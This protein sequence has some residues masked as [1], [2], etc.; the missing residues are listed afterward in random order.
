MRLWAW[1]SSG[2]KP[3]LDD[4]PLVPGS[5]EHA[6]AA[7]GGAAI[8]GG[9]SRQLA[10]PPIGVPFQAPP[11]PTHFVSR[12][13][14]AGPIKERLLTE[15]GDAARVL[16]IS[17]VHGL[18]GIGKSVLAAALAYDA[19]VQ[20]HFKDGVLWASLGQQPDVL[21]L[22]SG[23]IQA[24]R[25]YQFHSL[26]IEA[27]SSHLRKLLRDKAC[28]LVIDDAWEA[29]HVLPLLAGGSG[30][31]VLITTRQALVASAAG[32]LKLDLQAMTEAQALELLGRRLPHPLKGA[33]RQQA[34]EVARLLGCLPLALELAAAHLADG[35][36]WLELR[37]ALEAQ[38]AR[39]PMLDA[40]KT[41]E[42]N[43]GAL[44]MKRGLQ[45][46]LALSLRPLTPE[47]RAAFAWLGVLPQDAVL[48]PTMAAA[49]WDL[50]DEAQA[51]DLLHY[52]SERALLLPGSPSID[53][54]LSYRVHGLLHEMACNLLTAPET[55]VQRGD[56]PGLGLLLP[57][58]NALFLG[59]HRARCA[60]APAA[61]SWHTLPNDGYIHARL[62]WHMQQASWVAE[63]HALLREETAAGRNAWFEARHRLG[64]TE[65]Y[66]Q[67]LRRAW[68][69]ACQAVPSFAEQGGGPEVGLQIRYAL[70]LASLNS[71]AASIPPELLDAL[72]KYQIWPPEQ[73]LAYA[74]QKPDPCQQSLALSALVKYLPAA[75]QEAVLAEGLAAVR[76]ANDV[77]QQAQALAAL[78]PH[79]APPL[80]GEVLAAVR[81]LLPAAG[82]DLEAPALSA[83]AIRLAQLG[84]PDEAL[85]VLAQIVPPHERAQGLAA[86]GPHLPPAALAAAL[87]LARQIP[88][89]GERALALLSLVPYL[90][91]EASAEQVKQAPAAVVTA[92][93]LEYARRLAVQREN[94]Y[95]VYDPSPALAPLIPLLARAGCLEDAV[96]LAKQILGSYHRVQALASLLPYLPLE[97]RQPTLAEAFEVA[98]AAWNDT[99]PLDLLASLAPYL[100]EDRRLA[101][102]DKVLAKPADFSEENRSSNYSED[103]LVQTLTALAPF[104]SPSLLT[105]AFNAA[106]AIRVRRLRVDALTVLAAHLPPEQQRQ[107]L[108][109]ALAAVQKIADASNSA[110]MLV[111]L[112][113]HIRLDLLPETLAVAQPSKWNRYRVQ[114][115]VERALHLADQNRLDE[116]LVVARQIESE[117]A[118]SA[119]LAD[120]AA[121]L[122]A[123][124]RKPLL[125]EALA[126]ARE[127]EWG[128]KRSQALVTVAAQLSG[129][130]RR[131]ALSE[132][133]ASARQAHD[134]MRIQALAALTCELPPLARW[135]AL[136]EA[137]LV[138]RQMQPEDLRPQAHA[139][140]LPCLPGP[141]VGWLVPGLLE[142][143]H[144]VRNHLV[145]AQT[146]AALLPYLPV[147]VR[148]TVLSEALAAARQASPDDNRVQALASLAALLKADASRHPDLLAEALTIV[149]LIEQEGF[150]AMA[151]QALAPHMGD[152]GLLAQAVQIAQVINDRL[153]RVK[154][155]AALAP[156]LPVEQQ[157]LVLAA[158]LEAARQVDN[159]RGRT[160]GLALLAPLLP[161]AQRQPVLA[162]ALSS[163][164]QEDEKW[165]RA[166]ALLA[167]AP[168]LAQLPAE[169][170]TP[171]W[172]ITLPVLAARSRQELLSDLAALEPVFYALGG[173]EAASETL[174]AVQDVGRWWP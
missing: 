22:L 158:A 92:D 155:L 24:L 51:G 62:V 14:A 34:L 46:S 142:Q 139:A 74:R 168:A 18:G 26:T 78:A 131:A 106:R 132:A 151:L 73:G 33:E 61:A 130:E 118:R 174:R 58:A 120:L 10:H 6:S 37:Q 119:L 88:V 140:L 32:A 38:P 114:G 129:A 104:L 165:D 36:D 87:E 17:A 147:G 28:L 89:E 154:A 49:L 69:M 100:P 171:L 172:H 105:E 59:R 166:Q 149:R 153:Y 116:A 112:L 135:R 84:Q 44:G 123:S 156:W 3:G 7:G 133:L 43:V 64:Q 96:A 23:W 145:R 107:A 15:P 8:T 11:L 12:P 173:E 125:T 127:V 157:T 50:P 93:V 164:S 48:N 79:L 128:D 134:L 85:A 21:S 25:D 16:A 31:R 29:A 162:E 1:I 9:V 2:H 138:A 4:Q 80:L 98:R 60:A 30:C 117:Q 115:L 148:Q 35:L 109:E 102:L 152:Q 86:L 161:E 143:A 122:P 40:P 101:V 20:A 169:A 70:M 108:S 55:P 53:G 82:G 77:Y 99:V 57:Q 56:L 95:S 27:A 13:D 141:L 126:A 67:D 97:Q 159:E 144:R 91:A 121:R 137:W 63:V 47:Q 66:L 111:T 45:A 81:Q 19:E 170:L 42:L 72:V 5:D 76:R 110:E 124:E 39:Q 52:L 103:L 113:P 150:R 75:Q 94:W 71:L 65:G 146:L 83:L 163:A 160:E 54:S 41:E 167:L 68:D 90:P 136:V